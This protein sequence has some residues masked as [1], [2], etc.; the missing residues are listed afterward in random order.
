MT[1]V[2]HFQEVNELAQTFTLGIIKIDKLDM[3]VKV[4]ILKTC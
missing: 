1:T 2:I 4:L 3:F